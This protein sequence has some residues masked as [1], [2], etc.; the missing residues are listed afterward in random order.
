MCSAANAQVLYGSLTGNV[1]DPASAV[2][3]GAHV[4]AV[5]TGTNVKSEAN[6][7]E[8]GLYR[9]TDLQAGIYSVTITSKSFRTFTETN[10]QVQAN[11]VRRVDVQLQIATTTESVV[12]SADAVVLQT[13][14]GDVHTEISQQEVEELPYN[15]TEGK[16]FQSLLLLQPGTATTAGTGEATGFVRAGET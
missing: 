5:N 16:N 1:T 9:F 11:D 13:D 15:G 3:P 12:V 4:E 10:V 14:K 8:R 7:D 6:T 2:V